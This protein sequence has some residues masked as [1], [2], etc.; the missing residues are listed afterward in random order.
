MKEIMIQ[1]AMQ[2][3]ENARNDIDG[4][5]IN[6]LFDILAE[7]EIIAENEKKE[8]AFEAFKTRAVIRTG[9]NTINYL[10]ARGARMRKAAK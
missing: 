9:I 6:E 8:N 7:L 4:D 2:A 10:F 3:I 1:R 5:Y